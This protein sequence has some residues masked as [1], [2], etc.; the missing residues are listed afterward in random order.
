MSRNHGSSLRDYPWQTDR[1]WGIH[2]QR[3]VKA[4]QE[5]GQGANAR[6]IDLIFGF[7]GAPDLGREFPQ[8]VGVR[9]E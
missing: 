3:F 4:S 1:H 7:E 6:E 2:T 8:C 5:I 9:A